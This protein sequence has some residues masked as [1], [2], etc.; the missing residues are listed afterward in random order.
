[1]VLGLACNLII[2]LWSVIRARRL[3]AHDELSWRRIAAQTADW[4]VPLRHV[5]HRWLHS[6]LSIVFH[7]GVIVTP[8]FVAGH[9]W[10][11]RSNI[12]V[13]WWTLPMGTADVLTLVT[14]AAALALIASR[15]A[16]RASRVISRAQDW[17]IPVLLAIPLASGYL[18]ANPQVN[19]FPYNPTM[20]VHT[21]SAG[22]CFLVVPFTKLAHA[23][24]FLIARLPSELGWRFPDGYPEAVARQI[25]TEGRPI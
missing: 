5:R 12:G 19:P 15:L 21:L 13:S 4:I 3:T 6:G 9:V 10:L 8:V 11:I 20:L 14:I 16:T 1:M 24:L 25:G 22:L 17:A 7:V 18:A 2:A 23:A